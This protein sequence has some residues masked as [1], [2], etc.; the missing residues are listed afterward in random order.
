MNTQTAAEKLYL[1][2]ENL[3][4]GTLQRY[5]PTLAFDEDIQQS[6]R[7]GLW[8]ACLSYQEDRARFSTAA[9]KFIANEVLTELRKKCRKSKVSTISLNTLLHG[10][11][12]DGMRELDIMGI[13]PCADD[14][15]W[16]DIEAFW[17]LLTE[18][19]R[20]IVKARLAGSIDTAIA[21]ELGVS[22]AT[23]IREKNII[24]RKAEETL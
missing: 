17:E 9:Y 6:A 7:I 18:R 8:K 24:R 3:V 19:Q 15:D 16:C 21:R 14:I 5:F 10:S 12:I 1:E 11:E 23:V 22:H 4:Y 2:N 20:F 13:L